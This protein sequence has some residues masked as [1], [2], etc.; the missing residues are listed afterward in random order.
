M[1]EL[2]PVRERI[3]V[4]DDDEEVSRMLVRILGREG[5]RC[6]TVEDGAHAREALQL[7]PFDLI[8]CDV[9]LPGESGLELVKDV[10]GGR[11]RMAALMVSGLDYVSPIGR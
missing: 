9:D 3:L 4:V 2:D 10:V 5:Y 7:A 8:L 1:T 11:N 6:T